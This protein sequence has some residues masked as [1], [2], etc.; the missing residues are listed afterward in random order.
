MQL[1]RRGL[2]PQ[3]YSSE[4]DYDY[5]HHHEEIQT[6][7]R[8]L[9]ESTGNAQPH[10]LGPVALCH[11][12]HLTLSPPLHTIPTPPILPTQSIASTYGT[13]FRN[14]R[15]LHGDAA[16]REP[17]MA[18]PRGGRNPI[19]SWKH[20]A[21]YRAKVTQK[22][23]E[24]EE[25]KWPLYLE[26]AFLDAL[27]LIPFMG[28]KKFTS[29]GQLYGRN[30]LMTEYLWI[31][32][33]LL[34]P[35][36]HGET[37]PTG[38]D[39]EE[40]HMF[41]GRKRVSSHI[42]VLKGFFGSHP[43]FHFLFPRKN[44]EKE[45]EDKRHAKEEEGEIESFKNN[46]VLIALSEGRLPD[47]RPNYDY[48]ARLLAADSDVFVRP[49]RCWIYVS[50]SEVT[51]SPDCKEAIA[52]D[53]TILS[54]DAYKPDGQRQECKGD[55]PHLILNSN[56]ET[57]RDLRNGRNEEPPKHLLHEYTRTLDQKESNSV[58]EISAKWDRRFPDLRDNLLAALSETHPS[59][60]R[61]SRCVVGP[62]D[63]IQFEVVLDLHATSRFPSGTHLEGS[64]QLQICRPEL[65]NHRWRSVTSVS[66]PE[67]LE[68]DDNEAPFWNCANA[69]DLVGR[70][71]DVIEVPFPAKSWASTFMALSKYV[72][73]DR[74][75]RERRS[76]VVQKEEGD[77]LGEQHSSSNIKKP[78][79]KI[80]T[81]TELLSQVAMYQEIW[82]A[83]NDGSEKPRWTRRAI[84]LWTFTNVRSKTDKKGKTA[85]VPPGTRWRFL[86]KIDPN[87]QFHQQRALVSGSPRVS[88]DAVMSPTPAYASHF[89]TAAMQENLSN[90]TYE[91]A[92]HNIT[93][94]GHSM[95]PY[96]STLG[97][98][99]SFS[100]GGL[101]TPPPTAS[102]SSYAH[103]FD[104]ATISSTDSLHHHV[105]FLS[106]GSGTD[107]QGTLVGGNGD[108]NNADPF[109]IGLGVPA[110]S[111]TYD[112]DPNLQAWATTTAGGLGGLDQWATTYVDG[113][114][115]LPWADRSA[116][117]GAHEVGSRDATPWDD[118]KDSLWATADNTTTSAQQQQQQ[119]Q[120]D[121]WAS[122]S[123]QAWLQSIAATAD[124]STVR[125]D[126]NTW[127]DHH[128]S[129]SQHRRQ[130]LLEPS[131]S[132]ATP[133]LLSAPVHHQHGSPAAQQHGL[134]DAAGSAITLAHTDE[135]VSCTNTTN[136][137]KRA[138]SEGED[139]DDD[140]ES[141]P[142]SSVRKLA[143]ENATSSHEPAPD[144][145]A[146]E[147]EPLL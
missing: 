59:H 145:L 126:H 68:H 124:A 89:T 61:T 99:D 8:P 80:Y 104:S 100:S 62:S 22:E 43:C 103:S 102:L 119:R 6:T 76:K 25:P 129:Q 97:L 123:S 83:P 74:D 137:R 9:G 73:A 134:H 11:S 31:C 71:K 56:K 15:S 3:G 5:D 75:R 132:A 96:P 58:E 112:E 84:V 19:Y 117:I 86:T 110:A 44:D 139:T 95:H 130:T 90:A 28:R 2:L 37:V 29:K 21:D 87:S 127:V 10:N 77:N 82:S 81:P 42:Q 146:D 121:V 88:R 92:P 48:F 14:H 106:D 41:R 101:A 38:K 142:C 49:K 13:S 39:R 107:S 131:T 105:S 23:S 7:R 141:F 135:A 17:S 52:H 114:H 24:N 65:A 54:A 45:E 67:A 98:L 30:M 111:S 138:R 120:N 69:C 18:H 27:L 93:L 113:Q 122:A 53:G 33:W 16:L 140:L 40:H 128:D 34:F 36:Q 147:H 1:P 118:G 63:T 46:R 109:L 94:P 144:M 64:V 4:G 116:G 136:G 78:S 72:T 57:R 108:Q 55:Y 79:P 35:P 143:H 60:E 133:S 20:F 26:D 50:S 47:E 125:H 91:A 12:S 70:Q 32:H 85:T 66:K 51:L 115:N